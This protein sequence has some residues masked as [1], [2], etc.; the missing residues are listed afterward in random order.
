MLI[1][2]FFKYTEAILKAIEIKG[3]KVKYKTKLFMKK[4]NYYIVYPLRDRQ[5]RALELKQNKHVTLIA[6]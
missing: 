5:K 1:L 2:L 3:E 6:I 4:H